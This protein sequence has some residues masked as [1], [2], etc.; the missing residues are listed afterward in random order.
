[1]FT[2]AAM[3]ALAAR[4]LA[5]E[6][7]ARERE[8]ESESCI[9]GSVR[10]GD[11]GVGVR[12]NASA[13]Y[14][15]AACRGV[16]A[17]IEV[18]S[19]EPMSHVVASL[20][21]LKREADRAPVR[22]SVALATSGTASEFIRIRDRL[23][24]ENGEALAVLDEALFILVLEPEQTPSDPDEAIWALRAWPSESRVYTAQLQ[25]VVFGNGRAGTIHSHWRVEG[26]HAASFCGALY[27]RSEH[28][29]R[30]ACAGAPSLQPEREVRILP[31]NLNDAIGD[32]VEASAKLGDFLLPTNRGF[33]FTRLVTS[34]GRRFAISHGVSL[35]ALL[36]I[37]VQ[38]A[39]NEVLGAT[40]PM[41]SCVRGDDRL[42]IDLVNTRET[43][44][45]VELEAERP[46][47][48]RPQLLTALRS[49]VR[50]HVDIS[51]R[52]RSG[53]GPQGTLARTC[54]V[55]GT[56]RRDRLL[57][58]S[59]AACLPT[60]LDFPVEISNVGMTPGVAAFA[61][62][63]LTPTWRRRSS[64]APTTQKASWSTS[65]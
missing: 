43:R 5:T 55:L 26:Q 14:F 8:A 18:P 51:E 41:F 13:T 45:F 9:F 49:A 32:D 36:C 11:S 62:A 64:S 44:M 46:R 50:A 27:E 21:A 40:I 63:A 33:A 10:L 65:C 57:R 12:S 29:L 34:L 28:G 38:M 7:A 47:V 22:R 23:R 19:R 20:R 35:D 3:L 56:G 37:A 59:V 39:W 2:R 48:P 17:R 4:D 54:R 15:V 30:D 31:L 58:R 61:H 1:M 25:I 16:F 60:L 6:Q 42:N 52:V 24:H 53:R